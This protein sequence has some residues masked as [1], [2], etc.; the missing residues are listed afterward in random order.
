MGRRYAVLATD[1]VFWRS[2]LNNFYFSIMVVPIQ[3]GIALGPGAA[4]QPEVARQPDVPDDLLQPGRD[5]DGGDLGRL[6][7]SLQSGLSG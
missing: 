2:L 3:C 6:D 5:L 1:P 7:L 4:G